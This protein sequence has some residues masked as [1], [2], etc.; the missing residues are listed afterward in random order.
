MNNDSPQIQSVKRVFD[1]LEMLAKY[2]NGAS[3]RT[4]SEETRLAKSTTHRMLTNLIDLGYV[5][6]SSNSF[7]Y[8]LTLKMFELSGNALNGMDIFSESKKF[9]DQ[10]A[11]K[12]GETVHLSIQNGTDCVYIYK[13]ESIA[14]SMAS[15]LGAR[16]PMYCTAMGKAILSTFPEYEVRDIWNN[17]TIIKHTPKTNTDLDILLHQLS[18]IRTRG[19]AVDDEEN[20]VG[21][22]CIG[23]PLSKPGLRASAAFSLSGFTALLSEARI[24]SYI[25]L[26]Q[27]TQRAILCNLG[28]Y[29]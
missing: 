14:S 17:S 27:Q 20:E 15:R 7:Q 8:R 23:F 18:E 1:V 2:P 11:L 3:L 22:R 10:L 29:Y 21:V 4:V 16:F 12:T 26:S 13:A 25:N 5:V 24:A 28:I 6:Q 9:L 19:Y